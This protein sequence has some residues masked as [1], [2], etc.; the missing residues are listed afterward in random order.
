[1][2]S[3]F[4]AAHPLHEQSP[5]EQGG[6]VNSPP[7]AAPVRVLPQALLLHQEGRPRLDEPPPRGRRHQAHCA[8][9]R[10]SSHGS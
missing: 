7:E 1:M 6:L 5:I 8:A 10:R 4:P 2:F 9:E 3:L